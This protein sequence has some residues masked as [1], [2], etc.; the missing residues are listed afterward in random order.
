MRNASNLTHSE[1][2]PSE[3]K[4][5]IEDNQVLNSFIIWKIKSHFSENDDLILISDLL[6]GIQRGFEETI[7]VLNHKNIPSHV[8]F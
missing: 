5:E 2:D 7:N 8:N 4:R 1:F 6:R 3:F